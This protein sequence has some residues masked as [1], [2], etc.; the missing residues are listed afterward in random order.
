M[1]V[2]LTYEVEGPIG[3]D[4]QKIE[5][6]PSAI[7][8]GV[9]EAAA[10]PVGKVVVYDT[11]AGR[12]LKAVMQPSTTA[13][14]TTLVGVAGLAMWDPTYPEPPYPVGQALPVMRKGRMAIQPETPLTVHTNP[15]V[16]FGLVGAG[17]V[18]GALRN[19][20][21]AGNAVAAPY[22]TVVKG[23]TGAGDLAIV[24]IDL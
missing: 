13:Q 5:A 21:D 15:F 9:A 11:G 8:T 10:V 19:D 24:E 22:L 23:S 16:R 17:T 4:G 20:A 7:A 3:V 6:Y 2:Q 12:T 14:V 1:P 18:L